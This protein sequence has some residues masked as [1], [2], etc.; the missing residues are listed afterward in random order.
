M[1]NLVAIVGRPN[2]GKSALFNKMAKRQISIV[3]DMPGT[4]RDRVVATVRFGERQYELM[5]T[6][7]IGV[8][9]A[10]PLAANVGLEVD[11]A[12]TRADLILLVVD[13]QSGL[14]PVDREIARKL[15]KS[16]KEVFLVINKVDHDRQ[17][18][19]EMG[20]RKIGFREIHTVSAA[21]GRGIHALEEQVAEKVGQTIDRQALLKK[22]V[23]IAIVG[24]PNVGKSS[25]VNRLLEDARTIVSDLPG[26]TRDSVDLPFRL[27]H[28]REERDYVLIDTAGMR[29]RSK[30]STSVEV[31]SVMRAEKSV[32]RADLVVLV[33][34]AEVGVTKQDKQI[35]GFVQK[36]RKPMFIVINKWDLAV[37]QQELRRKIQTFKGEYE[38]ALHAQLFFCRY[39]PIIFLSAKTGHNIK[40]FT[41]ALRKV[42]QQL[43]IRMSTAELNRVIKKALDQNPPPTRGNKRMKLFYAVQ[44]TDESRLVS[45]TFILFVNDPDMFNDSFDAYLSAQLRKEFGFEGCPILFE[46]RA[47]ENRNE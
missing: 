37:D 28:G 44:K 47:R 26:T 5:D 34:D 2:V 29:H 11:I 14:H 20:F 43:T 12:V 23:K 10:D 27:K 7:G 32:E 1:S 19:D 39:A 9:T 13:G 16:A 41:T 21:H 6:G 3:H 36:L 38:E 8:E 17:M 35:A 33:L 4:T 15:R 45:P 40:D 22:P 46:L 18:V 31:F 24:K 42:E 25:L 30:V